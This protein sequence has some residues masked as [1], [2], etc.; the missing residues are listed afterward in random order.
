M[1]I[2]T[3]RKRNEAGQRA[4]DCLDYNSDVLE[5]TCFRDFKLTTC[6]VRLGQVCP[7]YEKGV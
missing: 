5:E 2:Y 4:I 7:Y 1:K 3:C 6:I